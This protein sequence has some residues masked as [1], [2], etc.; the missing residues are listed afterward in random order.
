MDTLAISSYSAAGDAYGDSLLAHG[1]VDNIIV[2]L[3][4]PPVQGLTGAVSHGLWQV[5]FNER[6]NWLYTLQRTT[7]FVSWRAVAASMSGNATNLF[8]QDT[9][10]PEDKGFYRVHAERP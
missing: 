4:P 9:N 1:A 6:T 3:P 8:L 10:A 7:N 2:T 5:Q